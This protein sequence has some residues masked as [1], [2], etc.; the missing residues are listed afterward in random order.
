[1]SRTLTHTLYNARVC[2][3]AQRAVWAFE[4]TNLPYKLVEIDLN[5]K[6]A[7]YVEKIN[8]LGKVPA[9]KLG[10]EDDEKAPIL[11]ESLIISQYVADLTGRLLPTDALIRAQISLFTQRYTDSVVSPFFQYART[12]PGEERATAKAK[13]FEGLAYVEELFEEQQTSSSSKGPY[14]LGEELSLADINT[15][16]HHARLVLALA[17]FHQLRVPG[18]EKL[19]RLTRWFNAIQARPD[20][21]RTY[22]KPEALIKAL[23]KFFQDS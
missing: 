9:L 11:V 8:P 16:T 17:H 4:A 15:A 2:P 21:Q 1:M 10:E 20:W 19:P 12:S 7:W 5:N 23:S 14:F 22:E 13:L 6:P 18:E 3:Y